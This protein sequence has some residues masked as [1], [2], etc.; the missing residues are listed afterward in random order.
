[1]SST[2]S[3]N[4]VKSRGIFKT[5]N[6]SRSNH[7]QKVGF[8]KIH[9]HVLINK[10]HQITICVIGLVCRNHFSVWKSNNLQYHMPGRWVHGTND[11]S[12][13][14]LMF[15]ALFFYRLTSYLSAL[16]FYEILTF[17]SLKHPA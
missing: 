12:T 8:L 2:I 16:G 5:T 11:S 6:L 14:H 10:N 13:Y 1:M 17:T 4:L 9:I 7:V 3:R 15:Q